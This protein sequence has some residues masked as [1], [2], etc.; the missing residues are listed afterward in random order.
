MNYEV[1]I[2]F[3]I[4]ECED[5]PQRPLTGDAYASYEEVAGLC[6]CVK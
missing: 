5:K 1:G 4:Y 6:C 2:E 3:R